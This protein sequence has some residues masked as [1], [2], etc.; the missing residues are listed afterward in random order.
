M[1]LIVLM[2]AYTGTLT[3]FLTVPKLKPTISTIEEL[4]ASSNER[5][6]AVEPDTDFY[7]KCMVRYLLAYAKCDQDHR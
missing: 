3:A 6:L 2:N 5:M 7:Y 4:E 1:S